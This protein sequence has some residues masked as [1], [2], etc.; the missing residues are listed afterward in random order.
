MGGGGV[1]RDDTTNSWGGQ[2]ASASE[3]KRGMTRGGGTVRSGQVEA[4]PVGRL[5]H[6]MKLRRWRTRGNT[7]T[8]QGRQ[9]A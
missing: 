1:S 3:K 6:D 4:P 8:S 9:E 5:W 2:E 7:T